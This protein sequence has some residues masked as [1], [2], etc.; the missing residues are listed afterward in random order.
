MISESVA[1]FSDQ[2]FKPFL[3]RFDSNGRLK[4]NVTFQSSRERDVIDQIHLESEVPAIRATEVQS[5][6]DISTAFKIIN[7]S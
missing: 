5:P 2:G 6:P 3:T 1:K 7:P 4:S